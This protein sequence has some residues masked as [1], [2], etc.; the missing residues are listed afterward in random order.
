MRNDFSYSNLVSRCCESLDV[1]VVVGI[2]H[3]FPVPPPVVI[4]A[5]CIHTTTEKDPHIDNCSI[6]L[7]IFFCIDSSNKKKERRALTSWPSAPSLL[8][9]FLDCCF[10]AAAAYFYAFLFLIFREKSHSQRVGHRQLYQCWRRFAPPP[11]ET[12]QKNSAN[13]AETFVTLF[14]LIFLQ[15]KLKN[16][17]RVLIFASSFQDE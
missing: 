11:Q 10:V 1:I 16:Q 15:T 3:P 17:K 13:R 5:I 4:F 7:Q 6:F 12:H 8:P 9:R 2:T 14:S